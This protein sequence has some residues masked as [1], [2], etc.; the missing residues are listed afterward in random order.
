M[1][2]STPLK[3]DFSAGEFA[4]V[5]ESRVDFQRF[6]SGCRILENFL[7][8]VV[9]AAVRRPGVRFIAST[10]YPDKHA[11]LFPFQYSTEQAYVLEFGDL[12]VRFYRNDGPLLESAKTISAATQANPV[13]L[14][15]NAHGYSNG[16]DFEC[17]G[18]VGMT[19]LNGRRFRVAN[20]ATNTVELTDQHGTNING[21]AYSAYVS[22]G[23][24]NRVYT[25]TTTYQE[26]DLSLLKYAQKA[27]VFYL[28]NT[29]YV[30]RKLERYGATNWVLSQIDFQDGPYL[31]LN[32]SQATLAKSATSGAGVTIS[33]SLSQTAT[34]M[35]NNGSG[36][37]RV[38]LSAHGWKTGDRIDI[39][40]TTGTVESIGTWTVIRVSASTFDLAGSTFA[41]AWAAGGTIKPHI[42]ESTDVGRLIRIQDSS[43]WGYAKIVGYTSAVSV[44]AD[45]INAFGATTAVATWRLGLYS[46]GGGYPSSVTFYEGRLFWGGCPLSPTRVDGSMSG[47]AYE[48]FA[49]TTT[50]GVVNDDNAVSYPLDSGDVNNVLWMKDDEKG[51]IVGTKGGEWL[52]RA[53]SQNVALTPTNVKATRSTTYGSYEG[54]QPVRTGKD[55][56]MVQRLRKKLRNLFYT[57]EIDG[58][59]ASDL[60]L[61]APHIGQYLFGQVAFQSEPE[62]WVWCTRADGQVGSLMYE[63]SESKIGWGRQILGG[64][65]D[66]AKRRRAAAESVAVIPS[67]TDSRDE[68]WFLAQRMINGKTERYVEVL[69]EQWKVGDDQLMATYL[70]SCLTFDGAISQTLQPGTGANI[71]GT[72]GVIF[73]AGGSTFVVGDV[74]REITMRYFSYFDP[75]AEPEEGDESEDDDAAAIGEWVTARAKITGYTSATVVTAKI[76]TAW[77]DLTLVA[78]GGWRLSAT[79]LT[80]LWHLEGETIRLNAE[81]ATHPDVTVTNGRAQLRRPVSYAVAGLSYKSRLQTLRI[82]GGSQDGTAQ[83]KKKRFSEVIIRCVQTLG[84]LIGSNFA[85]S[86]MKPIKYRD[87]SVPMGQ[88]TRIADG[89]HEISP[90]DKGWETAGRICVLNDSPFPMTIA[91][92]IPQLNVSD[93][94]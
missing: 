89:D 22:G 57:Y 8:L 46:Q 44:T 16:D 91:A 29:E 90:W 73:T 67:P 69:T 77:P 76:L 86:R 45:V 15:I 13:V 47:G 48:L 12:Y 43:T 81:G 51:L 19:Q 18:I 49:P 31:P 11:I 4:P 84:G 66:T 9:G 27:D 63:R 80:N 26:D 64:F 28:A 70:D 10:R 17:S 37:I 78:S 20:K 1:T 36:A 74:G 93:K 82:E 62:G 14:T 3:N 24:A 75:E 2:R 71:K 23:S 61:L 59:D 42:F 88:A 50:A 60:T 58:F 5:A 56:L 53:S 68:V 72:A 33:N 52:L 39:T 54:S 7:P 34:G 83:G 55:I 94:G 35:A 87:S 85:R 38:T 65:I 92:I 25:L 79:V 40:G 41:N 30:P 32:Q 21:T 6:P